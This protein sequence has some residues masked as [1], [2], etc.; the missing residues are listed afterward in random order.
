VSS[1]GGNEAFV[2][3]QAFITTPQTYI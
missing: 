3:F 1:D 2:V